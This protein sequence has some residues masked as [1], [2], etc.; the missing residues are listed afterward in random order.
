M[1]GN[2]DTRFQPRPVPC[3]RQLDRSYLCAILQARPIWLLLS[4]T[5][6]VLI[7]K[8]KV[9][10]ACRISDPT[11]VIW[12]VKLYKAILAQLFDPKSSSVQLKSINVQSPSSIEATWTKQGFLQLPWQPYLPSQEGTTVSV[13]SMRYHS[14]HEVP[15]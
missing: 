2:P 8:C 7:G 14:Q 5:T 3:H 6:A 1:T 15:W 13:S 11:G 10:L 9:Q 4:M 12:G